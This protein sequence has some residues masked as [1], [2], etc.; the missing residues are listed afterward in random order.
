M[1]MKNLLLIHNLEMKNRFFYTVQRKCTRNNCQCIST[2]K[3]RVKSIFM[4]NSNPK[5]TIV[6]LYFK[7][8]ASARIVCMFLFSF[9]TQSANPL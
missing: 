7:N 9:R 3:S 8:N 1:L 6:Y 2:T 4:L 5:G